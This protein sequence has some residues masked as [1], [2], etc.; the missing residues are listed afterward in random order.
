MCLCF[1]FS[2][3]LWLH[4]VWSTG[5]QGL[6]LPIAALLSLAGELAHPLHVA[7]HVALR[8]ELLGTA[9]IEEREALW[10]REL[11]WLGPRRAPGATGAARTPGLGDRTH[12]ALAPGMDQLLRWFSVGQKTLLQ[13]TT[14]LCELMPYLVTYCKRLSFS[15]NPL[16]GLGGGE[17]R[18]RHGT[19]SRRPWGRRRGTSQLQPAPRPGAPC[20]RPPFGPRPETPPRPGK[21]DASLPSHFFAC[22]A[23]Q[24]AGLRHPFPL[25][26]G[27][28]RC[29]S[30]S[31]SF[32]VVNFLGS[33]Y[34]L[35]TAIISNFLFSFVRKSGV[36]MD[37]R[38]F[39]FVSIYGSRRC[40]G[41]APARSLRKA[42][43]KSSQKIAG[44]QDQV[45][46]QGVC[47]STLRLSARNKRLPARRKSCPQL[48]RNEDGSTKKI[49]FERLELQRIRPACFARQGKAGCC[50]EDA[51]DRAWHLEPISHLLGLIARGS[52]SE[53]RARAPFTTRSCSC[54]KIWAVPLERLTWAAGC[55]NDWF[56]LAQ[57]EITLIPQGWLHNDTKEKYRKTIYLKKLC[58]H[59]IFK[60]YSVRIN[61]YAYYYHYY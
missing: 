19:G 29:C 12:P 36:S 39:W 17:L 8:Y 16:P 33:F 37:M 48:L 53:V 56:W 4:C 30:S 59:I 22:H 27:R 50:T 58:K 31:L 60:L 35:E 1:A 2:T 32:C 34:M 24:L 47:A 18:T 6:V 44:N 54:L 15:R 13:A 38:N 23:I 11:Q 40:C 46:R 51:R 61:V 45:H 5:L 20:T 25:A 28:L 43:D 26:R 3:F 10:G 14:C 42:W 49:K 9:V 57:V 7:L 52:S 21:W 55:A 41:G